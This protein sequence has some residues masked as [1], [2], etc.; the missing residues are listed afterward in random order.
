MPN[1][2]LNKKGMVLYMVLA[3]ILVAL[4][5]AS[6]IL[7]LILSQASFSRHEVKRVQVYYSALAG[8]NYAF[9]RL[10]SGSQGPDK[11]PPCW[12]AP[13]AGATY[14]TTRCIYKTGVTGTGICPAA[15]GSCDLIDDSLPRSVSQVAITLC[16]TSLP[17]CCS[18]DK[19]TCSIPACCDTAPSGTLKII[20]TATYTTS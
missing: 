12:P 13:P 14:D 16:G 1:S 19:R 10:R 17:A 4:V 7:N 9:E 20:S 8:A 6:S 11:S 2:I 18:S 5:L 3:S 15:P